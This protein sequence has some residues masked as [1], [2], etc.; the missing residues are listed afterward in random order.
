MTKKIG[1]GTR[2]SQVKGKEK[3]L[4]FD[5]IDSG[6]DREAAVVTARGRT[7]QPRYLWLKI[8][9]CAVIIAVCA[10][11]AGLL[12]R[13]GGFECRLGHMIFSSGGER[14]RVP[15]GSSVTVPY[16]GGLV[17]ER[18]NLR[19]VYRLLPPKGLRVAVR[20]LPGAGDVT[21]EDITGLIRPEELLDYDIVAE[22]DGS[23]IGAVS[24]IFEMNAQDWISRA[25]AVEDVSV[26]KI[27]YQKAVTVDPD[28]EV[29]HI[30]LGRLYEN[31]KKIKQAIAEYR[32]ATRINPGN[33]SG[34][35][36]LAGLY[37][38][39]GDNKRLMQ[40]YEKLAEADDARADT[41]YYRAGTAAEKRG[42]AD[43]AMSL[44][45]KALGKNRAHLDARRR[46]I[47]IYERGKQ[48]NRAA[49]NTRVLLEYQPKNDELHLYLS[50][51]Y[52][53]MGKIR[54]ALKSAG[55][56]E[57]LKPRD[58]A[59]C[60][61]LAVLYERAKK[62]DKAIAYYKK[63]LD[64]NPRNAT[65]CNNLGLLQ[66]Q[67]GEHKQA[68]VWYEKAVALAPGNP[69]FAVNLA[70][71]YETTKQWKKAAGVYETIVKRDSSNIPAWEALAE[72]NVKTGGTWKALEAYAALANLE[73]R[74]VVW[75]Q[76]VAL[77]YEKLG[78]VDKARKAYEKI[79][80]LDP[81]N[82]EAKDRYLELSK[83]RIMDR[84]K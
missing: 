61:Q 4:D 35:Q 57:K 10:A 48:W 40:T 62:A 23:A 31:E 82:K 15:S 54:A 14:I 52:I 78:K 60:L 79:L 68:I 53:R 72:L 33:V 1:L 2:P 29:A 45:R 74:K 80:E 36:S 56:A 19:G 63:A 34:L 6:R 83:R 39:T 70:D 21:G 47:R 81:K 5:A 26:R 13:D 84:V 69:G 65:A 64:I 51:L 76:K 11:G 55:E 24:L 75:R 3:D 32:V 9:S 12:L 20:Q 38:K 18:I 28:S 25:D 50:E 7:A 41:H 77:L 16:G 46:L 58:E 8:V 59:L 43:K 44:Y 42:L 27:C 49:A 22:K 67:Q 17:L 66:E 30:A 71:A 37:E 73:P